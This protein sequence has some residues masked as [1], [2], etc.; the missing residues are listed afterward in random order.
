MVSQSACSV[1]KERTMVIYKHDAQTRQTD[2]VK[3]GSQYDAGGLSITNVA[4]E[5]IF[6]Q[7]KFSS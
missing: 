3:A 2:T 7:V 6:S 1:D 5:S 4:E